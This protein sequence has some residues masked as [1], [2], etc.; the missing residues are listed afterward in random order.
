MVHELG[1]TI[2]LR[3]DNAPSEGSQG[4]GYWQITNTPASDPNSVMQPALNGTTW[5]GFSSYDLIAL[6][7]MY[8]PVSITRPG[9]VAANKYCT[10]T[11]YVNVGVPPY[12]YSWQV[13]PP[14]SGTFSPVFGSQQSFTTYTGSS[15]SGGVYISVTATDANGSSWQRTVQATDTGFGGSYDATYCHS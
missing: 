3:H 2:G 12:T 14:A 5:T 15:Y 8:N 4:V 11:A 7:Q 10:W 13:Q 1:H 6:T 9:T